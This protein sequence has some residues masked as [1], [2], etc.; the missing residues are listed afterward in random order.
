MKLEF[1]VLSAVWGPSLELAVKIHCRER[2]PGSHTVSSEDCQL[3]EDTLRG[4]CRQNGHND[5]T[6]R[7]SERSLWGMQVYRQDALSSPG[8]GRAPRPDSFPKSRERAPWKISHNYLQEGSLTF[9]AMVEYFLSYLT[10][11]PLQ[12]YRST[13][14]RPGGRWTIWVNRRVRAAP[15]WVCKMD[16]TCACQ[17]QSRCRQRLTGLPRTKGKEVCPSEWR[18]SVELQAGVKKCWILQVSAWRDG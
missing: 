7:M 5:P 3:L 15:Q 16:L 10:F 6:H 12:G 14:G 8:R 13:E 2:A 1:P 18:I 11:S 17:S 4:T 9:H